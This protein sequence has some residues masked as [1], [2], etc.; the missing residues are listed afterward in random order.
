MIYDL[1]FVLLK[2]KYCCLEKGGEKMFGRKKRILGKFYLEDFTKAITNMDVE[3]LE[4]FETA[5]N[6]RIDEITE[7][8]KETIEENKK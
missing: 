3:Y 4:R 5:L 2:L 8:E 6:A 1:Q 7:K